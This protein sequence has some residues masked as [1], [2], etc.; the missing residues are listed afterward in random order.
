MLNNYNIR[1]E[2]NRAR[3]R[4]FNFDVIKVCKGSLSRQTIRKNIR[5]RK[6]Y[7]PKEPTI[8]EKLIVKLRKNI[9]LRNQRRMKELEK[10]KRNARERFKL[11]LLS[12]ISSKSQSN[13]FL[14]TY[15]TFYQ[16]IWRKIEKRR[17]DSLAFGCCA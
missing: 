6:K 15:H 16:V 5:E 8:K 11:L 4:Y 17:P 14:C 2:A 13:I 10:V 9:K 3:I 7:R 1:K 12:L